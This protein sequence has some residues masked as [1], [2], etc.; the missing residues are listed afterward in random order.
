MLMTNA[1]QE[2]KK[3]EITE[4][5]IDVEKAI[6]DKNPKLARKLPRF[7]INY[8]KKTIH[9]KELN[10][11]LY[12][13][14]EKRNLEFLDAIIRDEW[15]ITINK[16]N[17]HNLPETGRYI[18][19]SNH[20]L[21]GLDGITLIAAIGEKRKNI[22]FPVN[23]IL[24]GVPTITD[25]FVPINKHKRAGS[26]E[27]IHTIN[28]AFESDAIMPYFPAGLVSRKKWGKG[29]VDLEWKK[30]FIIGAQQYDRTILPVHIGGRNSNKFYRIANLRK[31]FKIKANIEMLYLVDE[32]M[33]HRGQTI[34]IT[35]GKPIPTETFDKSKTLIEWAQLMKEHCYEL[36]KNP[37]AVF[38]P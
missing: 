4:N 5:F 31:F 22:K 23:D 1:T 9:Q 2:E 25:L 21:G 34:D 19:S 37:D 18:V 28:A 32:M 38:K 35:F 3:V 12:K 7:V 16:I 29:I 17:F 8:L 33:K 14:R 15:K 6:R 24:M 13:H 36:G 26:K 20:P 27:N 11:L 10:R 30:S